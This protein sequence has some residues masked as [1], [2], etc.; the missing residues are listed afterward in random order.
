LKRLVT[1]ALNEH[2]APIRARGA[3]L[4]SDPGHIGQVLAAGLARAAD[5]A[6]RTLDEVR[7]AMGMSY[8]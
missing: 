3:E 5:I 1:V 8:S 2:L 7:M 6:D 4:A